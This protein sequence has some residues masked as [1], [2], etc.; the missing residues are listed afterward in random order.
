MIRSMVEVRRWRSGIPYRWGSYACHQHGPR[1]LQRFLQLREHGCERLDLHQVRDE[2]DAG[3]VP[4]RAA[5]DGTSGANKCVLDAAIGHASGSR[6]AHHGCPDVQP[7]ALR[8]RP[9]GVSTTHS[10]AQRSFPPAR[11]PLTA[12]RILN[13]PMGPTPLAKTG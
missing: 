3:L 2:L 1:A 12:L 6:H 11:L 4:G 5:N 9:L 13:L 8:P 10:K 7:P